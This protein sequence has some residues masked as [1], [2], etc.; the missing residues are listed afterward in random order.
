MGFVENLSFT[1]E[2]QIMVFVLSPTT[3][4]R[5]KSLLFLK[6]WLWSLKTWS[7]GYILISLSGDVASV[8][9]PWK[10][11]PWEGTDRR[12]LCWSTGSQPSTVDSTS[13]TFSRKRLTLVNTLR[14]SKSN[15]WAYTVT[16]FFGCRFSWKPWY[17][18]A[19]I[20]TYKYCINIIYRSPD[21]IFIYIF[22]FWLYI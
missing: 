8:P 5:M 9:G 4:C 17:I 7:S 1:P 10:Q 11:R 19:D 13:K 18:F 15:V 12:K 20:Y 2:P 14:T 16:F 6:K 3:Y 21:Y 22:N